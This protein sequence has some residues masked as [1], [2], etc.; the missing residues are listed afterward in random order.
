MVPALYVRRLQIQIHD[1]GCTQASWSKS[2]L[3]EH[4]TNLGVIKALGGVLT[5]RTEVIIELDLYRG[6]QDNCD[7]LRDMAKAEEMQQ[8]VHAVERLREA[9]MRITM[10]CRTRWNE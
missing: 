9:D 6:R 3:S 10:S 7:G 4:K 5:T 8:L 2:K 1:D